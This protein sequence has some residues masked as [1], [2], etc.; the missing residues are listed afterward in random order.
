MK[1]GKNKTKPKTKQTKTKNKKQ[2]N[3]HKKKKT[4]LLLIFYCP[5]EF[6]LAI[7]GFYS[8]KYTKY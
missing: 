7:P 2:K 4:W 6:N 5:G 8:Y 1:D 3:T